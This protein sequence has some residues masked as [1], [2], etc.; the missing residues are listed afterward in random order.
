MLIKILLALAILLAVLALVAAFQSSTY[1]AVRS[2]TLAA[3][4]ARVFAQTNDLRKYQT[5][6]PFGKSDPAATYVYEGPATG[7]GSVLKWSSTGQ[8]GEGTMTIVESR[9]NELVRYRLVFVR[10]MA[11][12]GDMAIT[13]Q[14]QG[15]QTLVTWSMEGEK[16]YLAKVMCLF[17]SMEK[18]VGG[19][20]ERGLAELK[21][22]VEKEA[23]T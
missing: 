18:M 3:P 15:N 10:P 6:N 16:A 7:V 5:W 1:R 13:L 9:P 8:T 4:P 19:A 22:I 21:T 14:A 2:A 12:A 11:G 20:F 23:K 17:V